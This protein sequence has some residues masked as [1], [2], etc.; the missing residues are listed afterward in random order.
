MCG[1]GDMEDFLGYHSE[2]NLGSPG[3]WDYQ[4]V[5]QVI[6][7]EVWKRLNEIKEIGVDL[8]FDHPLL[9]PI[10]GFV[11]MLLAA[12]HRRE[13]R[14][15]GVIAVVAE[16]ESLKD[17]SENINLAAKL[18]EIEGITGVLLAPHELE[19]KN[20]RVCHK[21][22]PVSLIF[23]DFNTDILLSLHRKQNLSPLLAAVREGRV[24]NPR[25]TEPINVKSTFE[26]ITGPCRDRFH[27]ETVRRTPWTR[28]FH[29]RKT[30]GPGGEAIGDLTEWTRNHWDGLVLKPE[31][32]Y[33]GKGVRVGGVHGNV[34]EAIGI[35]LS[36]G[37]YIVQEKI[38]LP[39]WGE[40][41]PFVD[42]VRY[43]GVPTNVGSGGGVQP[44]AILRQEMTVREAVDRINEAILSIDY[45][46]LLEVV[47]MQEKM[48]LDH[49]F[50]YLLGP[51][52]MALRPRVMKPGHIEALCAYC[53]TVWSDCLTLEKMWLAGEIDRFVNIE[54]EEL[55]IARTQ[56]WGGS[57]AVF[58]S[59][60][61]FSFGAHPEGP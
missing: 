8:D 50:T 38:P 51:I 35:A 23:L 57:P 9:Y 49:K 10:D 1:E 33:S 30:E 11:A 43:G 4:R 53:T 26:L 24:I 31:R 39:L 32:G 60:G 2:W 15:P 7:K 55:A 36:A 25:G 17:V 44:L 27:P 28:K 45:A 58:A 6:G 40:D 13:G 5:T 14:N 21:G 47:Q 41:N 54:E 12:H 37:D 52:K 20:G 61:L 56:I 3:G 16:E 22:N 34:E 29:P 46:D 48:A 19:W 59:D 42:K 18:T